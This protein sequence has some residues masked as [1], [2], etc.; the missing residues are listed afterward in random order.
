MLTP[1]STSEAGC[2][3]E[4]V[5]ELNDFV[6]GAERYP[7]IV[8]AMAMRTHLGGLLRAMLEH[9][10]CTRQE[11]AE[12]LRELKSEALEPEED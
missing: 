10:E 1:G 11:I 4:C 7:N 2:F 6:V 9:G 5:D 12:F 3:E 8:L